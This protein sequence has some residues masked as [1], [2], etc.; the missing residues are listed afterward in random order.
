MMAQRTI[1]IWI[2][3]MVLF[4]A[5]YYDVEEVL[6]PPSTCDTENVSYQTHIVPILQQ[7]CFVC[8]SAAANLG[9]ITLEGYTNLMQQVNNGQLLGAI[10]HKPGFTAMPQG[11]AQLGSCDIAKIEQWI[12]DGAQN[13]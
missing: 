4:S 13:N 7:N 8:H 3:C 5:C 2:T 6:Y 12:T 1:K 11:A 9:S 10:Q